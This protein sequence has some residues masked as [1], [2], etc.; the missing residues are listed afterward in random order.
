VLQD[1][2]NAE[3][4][5]TSLNFFSSTLHIRLFQQMHCIPSNHST[6]S[7]MHQETIQAPGH[8]RPTFHRPTVRCAALHLRTRPAMRARHDQYYC[9]VVVLCHQHTVAPSMIFE[10]GLAVCISILTTS[11]QFSFFS[12]IT[13]APA[14]SYIIQSTVTSGLTISIFFTHSQH[15]Y[16]RFN[17]FRIYF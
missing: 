5:N 8:R 14:A 3:S 13:S 1:S 16:F 6:F 15:H 2:S 12:L 9:T 7:L 11:R 4:S 17:Y 10:A